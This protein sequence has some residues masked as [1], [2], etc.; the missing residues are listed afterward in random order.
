M[1]YRVEVIRADGTRWYPV[2]EAPSLSE[3]KV[4]AAGIWT[5]ARA[6]T[7]EPWAPPRKA[8]A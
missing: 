4:R 1:T 6:T 5:D 2:V 7:A 3:A 8:N